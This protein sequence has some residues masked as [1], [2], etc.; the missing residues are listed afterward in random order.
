MRMPMMVFFSCSRFSKRWLR[1]RCLL[2]WSGLG[3]VGTCGC[4]WLRLSLLVWCVGR[5]CL[6]VCLAWSSFLHMRQPILSIQVMRCVCLWVFIA[7]V[8]GVIL[9][10]CIV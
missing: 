10:L 6:I 2:T 8:G 7:R 9:L 5:C 1:L 4:F 3:V